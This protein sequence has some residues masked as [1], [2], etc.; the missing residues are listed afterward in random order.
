MSDFDVHPVNSSIDDVVECV[1][2]FQFFGFLTQES[3]KSSPEIV[4]RLDLARNAFGSLR[5]NI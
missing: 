4:K 1:K 5:S 2:C 3:G